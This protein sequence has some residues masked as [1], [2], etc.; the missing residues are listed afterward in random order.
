MN[1]PPQPPPPEYPANGP[2]VP[3]GHP[4]N[5]PQA[6]PVLILGI[7][8]LVLCGLLGPVAWVM[9]KRVLAQIDSSG[10]TVDGRTNANIGLIFVIAGG[11]VSN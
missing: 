8:S 4:P 5:H 11:G 9:G 1:Y 10:G 2:Y 7:L 3:C 6:N